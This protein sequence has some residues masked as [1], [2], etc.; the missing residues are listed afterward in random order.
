M[1]DESKIFTLI[2]GA[3]TGLG[4]ALAIECASR[5]MNLILVSLPGERLPHLCKWLKSEY[6]VSVYW[7]E[8]DLTLKNAPY[9]LSNWIND[10]FSIKIIINN[11]GI[12]GT[13]PF[14]QSPIKFI[15]DII[16][17][18]IR[19]VSVLTRLLIPELKRHKRA[20]IL[21]VASMAALYP[22]PYKSVYPAS[23]AFVYHFSRGL[24]EELRQTSIR[25]CVL[26]PGPI[27]TNSDVINRILKQGYLGRLGL[28]PKK[29]IA[30]I[31]ICSMLRERKVIVPGLFNKIYLVLV[32]FFPSCIVLPLLSMQLRKECHTVP[33]H[34]VAV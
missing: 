12:G 34:R 14:D 3:S 9:E 15:D 5:K 25:V 13:M 16:Q 18:N 30:R 20:Y 29:R 32:K 2:T 1:K 19:V 8:I 21:N 26:N 33:D 23:K 4:K 10:N 7:Y 28:L 6:K 24:H 27:M 31:A 11:A 17:L 22:M